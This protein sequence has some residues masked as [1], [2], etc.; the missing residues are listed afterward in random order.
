MK[1][2]VKDVVYL[3]LIVIGMVLLVIIGSLVT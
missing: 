1:D 2:W 3:G